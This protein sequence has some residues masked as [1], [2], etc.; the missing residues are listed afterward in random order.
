MFKDSN[1]KKTIIETTVIYTVF[2]I[3]T[4]IIFES[5]YQNYPYGYTSSVAFL[6]V[7]FFHSPFGLSIITSFVMLTAISIF[8]LRMASFADKKQ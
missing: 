2:A 1:L 5:F 6:N 7:F 3:V 8:A 4:L